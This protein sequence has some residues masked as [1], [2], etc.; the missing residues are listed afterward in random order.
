MDEDEGVGALCPD[1][2]YVVSHEVLRERPAGEGSDFLL[3]CMECS[4]VHTLQL[5]PPRSMTIP[6]MLSQGPL[7]EVAHIEI[8]AD[9]LLR[10]GDHFEHNEATWEINRL[11]DLEGNSKKR[12]IAENCV[13]ANALRSDL[14][15]VRLTMTRGGFSSSGHVIV[16]RDTIFKGGSLFEHEDEEWRIRAIHTGSGRTMHGKVVAQDIKRVYLHEKPPP[17]EFTAPRTER[18][19]RQ[20]WKEGRLGSNPNPTLPDSKKK[21][22]KNVGR[23]FGE[24]RR[25]KRKR[26]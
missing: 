12:L 19:R 2:D 10:I 11:E 18:E 5:R 26:R 7:T 17:E 1:C 21:D 22:R 23:T 15:R 3:R 25:L 16:E 6:F 13:R 8:D 4:K 9:E 24:T 20:A 14:I